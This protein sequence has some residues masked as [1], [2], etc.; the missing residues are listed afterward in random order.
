MLFM[1]FLALA[2]YI[3]LLAEMDLEGSGENPPVFVD[4]SSFNSYLMQIS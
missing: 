2:G 3:L 4:R 1:V